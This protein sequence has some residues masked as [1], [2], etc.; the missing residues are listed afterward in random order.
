[1]YP[2]FIFAEQPQGPVDGSNVTFT[3]LHIPN[4]PLSL[5]VYLNGIL[6]TQGTDFS[7]SVGAITFYSAPSPGNPILCYYQTTGT[8]SSATNWFQD[9]E[10]LIPNG[11]IVELQDVPQPTDSLML[12]RNG[13]LQTF[14]SDF[15]LLDEITIEFKVTLDPTDVIQAFYQV[16]GDCFTPPLFSQ[17]ES[18]G[19][20]YLD[21]V[22]STIGPPDLY[23]TL[24]HIPYYAESLQLY[25]NGVLQCLDIDYSLNG[26]LITFIGPNGPPRHGDILTA[27]YRYFLSAEC[28]CDPVTSPATH[29]EHPV[30]LCNGVN[31]I[32]KLSQEPNPQSSLIVVLNNNFGSNT[33]TQN[34]DFIYYDKTLQFKVAPQPGDYLDVSYYYVYTQRVQSVLKSSLIAYIRN[35]L[36]DVNG[37]LWNDDK[38]QYYINQAEI[39][40]TQDIN[41]IWQRFSINILANVGLYT[42]PSNLKSITRL[43]WMGYKVYL[44]SQEELALLSPT[45]RTQEGS[46]PRWA[47]LQFEG[48]FNLRLYPAPSLNLPI[49]SNSV[50]I[51]D[52]TNILN[53]FV[54]SAYMYAEE[55][56]P[57]I[58]VPDYF[59]RRSIRYNVMWKCYSMEGNGQNL[60]LADYFKKKY[61]VQMALNQ[62]YMGQMSA[63]TQKQYSDCAIQR[64]YRRAHPILPPNFGT[65]VEMP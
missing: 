5:Q 13:V 50:T 38:I 34:V 49:I 51:Y 63:M 64:P 54:V 8:Q 46:Q 15:F 6:L 36:N 53:E 32:F 62:K 11:S 22:H 3:L 35:Y 9:G 24:Q 59:H 26:S 48:Y 33:L 10:G 30:G 56:V 20:F 23:F 61:Y 31:L 52:D 55:F 12:F 29:G 7:L 18:C 41:I 19:G 1:M 39:D 44:V 21:P 2:N 37:K 16:I 17:Q 27:Y 43:T 57:Y 45:Y 28:I 4:P 42:L 58:E 25:W 14:G 47:T 40:L 60:V 65:V